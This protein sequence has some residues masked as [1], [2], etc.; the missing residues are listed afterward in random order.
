MTKEQ[1]LELRKSLGLTQVKFAA[2]LHVSLPT[3]KSWESGKYRPHGLYLEAL[4]E[5]K[6]RVPIFDSLSENKTCDSTASQGGT[7]Q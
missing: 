2:L 1:V 3:I 4:L 7:F 6:Q 5:V